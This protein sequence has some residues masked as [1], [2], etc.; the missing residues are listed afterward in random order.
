M[1]ERVLI[2][3]DLIFHSPKEQNVKSKTCEYNKT[4]SNSIFMIILISVLIALFILVYILISA[5]TITVSGIQ[6]LSEQEI[7]NIAGINNIQNIFA[8]N[9]NNAKSALESS[10]KIKS[11]NI[12]FE[13][14][15]RLHITIEERLPIGIIVIDSLDKGYDLVC[16]DSDGF[17]IGYEHE[18]CKF[19]SLPLI[20]GIVL[21]NYKLGNRLDARFIPVLLGI[22]SLKNENQKLF[23]EISEFRLEE[24]ANGYIEVIVYPVAFHTAMRMGTTIDP[25]VVQIG[26]WMLD[27]IKDKVGNVKLE[28]LDLRGKVYSIKFKEAVSG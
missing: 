20:S 4:Y 10:Y 8:I 6:V 1:S 23:E 15:N 27:A 18:Y 11:A 3:N 21:K 7:L 16:V 22:N 25:S 26:I 5:V 12:Q 19:N 28:E 13:M 9:I 2:N 24:K 14:L 17:L